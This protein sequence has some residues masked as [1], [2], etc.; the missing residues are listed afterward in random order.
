VVCVLS[1][2]KLDENSAFME[3]WFPDTKSKMYS[4][5]TYTILNNIEYATVNRLCTP[6]IK[7]TKLLPNI[8]HL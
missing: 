1:D 2:D 5:I 4:L 3:N 7:K 6:N 8:K